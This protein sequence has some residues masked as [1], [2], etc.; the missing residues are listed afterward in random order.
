MF[1]NPFSFEGRI[2][3]SEYWVSIF[4]LSF[5]FWIAFYILLMESI[6]FGWV[7]MIPLSWFKIAQSAKRCHDIGKDG[8][9]QL[10]PFFDFILLFAD[11]EDG[12]NRFGDNP[13]GINNEI[14]YQKPP[15]YNQFIQNNQGAGYQGGYSGGHNKPD[16]KIDDS[17]ANEYKIGD[18]Y[19]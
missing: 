13:K 16:G 19:K 8:A 9:W 12:I 18:L 1:L 7:I 2:R 11:S 10:I 14:N 4:I 5:S 15:V 17:S 6:F 3:R